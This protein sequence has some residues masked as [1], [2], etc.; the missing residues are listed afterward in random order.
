LTFKKIENLKKGLEIMLFVPILSC[1]F[2]SELFFKKI[3]PVELLTIFN[4]IAKF[5]E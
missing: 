4:T 5:P 1:A 3:L 2:K